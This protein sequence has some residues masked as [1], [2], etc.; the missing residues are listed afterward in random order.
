MRIRKILARLILVLVFLKVFWRFTRGISTKNYT[1]SKSGGKMLAGLIILVGVA[2]F[3]W[4]LLVLG[5][6]R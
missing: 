1:R 2:Y 4:K 3:I 5:V 6:L